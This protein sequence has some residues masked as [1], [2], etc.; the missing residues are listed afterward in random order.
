MGIISRAQPKRPRVL[1]P[2]LASYHYLLPALMSA[3]ARNWTGRSPLQSPL[4]TSPRQ[5]TVIWHVLQPVEGQLSTSTITSQPPVTTDS[6]FESQPSMQKF[7]SST[8]SAHSR[9]VSWRAAVLAEA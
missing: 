8:Q 2:A 6:I 9:I 1:F 7:G 4:R 5:F 3:R